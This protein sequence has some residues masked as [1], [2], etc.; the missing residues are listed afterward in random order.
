[1]SKN[2][3]LESGLGHEAARSALPSPQHLEASGTIQD[4]KRTFLVFKDEHGNEYFEIFR[5]EADQILFSRALREAMNVADIVV[6]KSD[7]V[8]GESKFKGRQEEI[9]Y[10]SCKQSYETA[11]KRTLSQIKADRAIFEH[12]FH[13]GDFGVRS[14]PPDKVSYFDFEEFGEYFSTELPNDT[15]LL[16]GDVDRKYLRLKLHEIKRRLGSSQGLDFLKGIVNALPE[17]PTVLRTDMK[18][19]DAMSAFQTTILKRIKTLVEMLEK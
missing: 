18:I 1:M 6:L 4:S 8:T 5:Y 3:P 14:I 10:F 15:H 11:Q 17:R 16:Q 9:R 13:E 2:S 7:Q 12:V 19:E